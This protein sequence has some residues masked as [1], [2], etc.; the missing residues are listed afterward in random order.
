TFTPW[1]QRNSCSLLV[2]RVS[3]AALACAEIHRSLLPIIWPRRS[4]SARG[5][6]FLPPL[7]VHW[8]FLR[9]CGLSPS[10]PGRD[11][12]SGKSARRFGT[13]STED[14]ISLFRRGGRRGRRRAPCAWP[15]RRRGRRD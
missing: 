1:T 8:R 3:P 14:G 2:T 4:R 9:F 15:F 11:R 5:R 10:R 7:L 12:S 13:R 6:K